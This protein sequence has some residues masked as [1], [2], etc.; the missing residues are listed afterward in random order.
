[1]NS[2]FDL[3]IIDDILLENIINKEF[4]DFKSD[5]TRDMTNHFDKVSDK[6]EI[7]LNEINNKV[8]SRIDENF[9]KTNKTFINVLE[10]LS[11]I[12][13]AQKKIERCEIFY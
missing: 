6:L 5:I 8:N 10:R 4:L 13:E 9:E 12:D 7:K 3:S 1:M 2:T 11:K